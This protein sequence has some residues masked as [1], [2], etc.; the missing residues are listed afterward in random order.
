L[1]A[2][3]QLYAGNS[4]GLK[5]RNTGSMVFDYDVDAIGIGGNLDICHLR[6]RVFMNVG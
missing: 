1:N 5:S 6:I 3:S 2:Y 4:E